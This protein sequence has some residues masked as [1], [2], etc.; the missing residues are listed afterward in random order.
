MI[1]QIWLESVNG[2]YVEMAGSA[3]ALN[4]CTDLANSCIKYV[5]GLPMIEWCNAIDFPSRAGSEYEYIENSPSAVPQESDLIIFGIGTYGHI[6]VFVEG[7]INSFRS[8]D[9]NY[10]LKTP[11][12]IVN[13]NYKNVL[14]WL[15]FKSG[16]IDD[17]TDEQKKVLNMLQTYQKKAEHSN[18]EGAMNA[19]IGNV[20]ELGIQKEAVSNL[21]K[22]IKK[23]EEK[24]ENCITKEEYNKEKEILQ[25]NFNEEKKQWELVKKEEIA[26]VIKTAKEELTKEKTNWEITKEEDIT[27]AIE[28]AII[29]SDK[30]WEEKTKG[31][32]EIKESSEYKFAQ[33]IFKLLHLTKKETK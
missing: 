26:E 5:F 25:N 1:F 27:K 7:N 21:N 8:M 10:P 32:N 2:E 17:M 33:L 9:Q 23:L 16:I 6:S 14:G 30:E 24:I 22:D 3:S 12:H 29:K 15:H 28:T 4:Q 13:H 19:L 31:Y 11:C 18:L 20:K